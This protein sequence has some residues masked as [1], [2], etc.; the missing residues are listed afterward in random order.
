LKKSKTQGAASSTSAPAAS[1][2]SDAPAPNEPKAPK[3]GVCAI[4][5]KN[6]G[7]TCFLN[8]ALQLLAASPL[9]IQSVSAAAP[10]LLTTPETPEVSLVKILL[11]ILNGLHRSERARI[12]NPT[13][14]VKLLPPPF[15]DRA[16]EHDA[17]EVLYFLKSKL[18]DCKR[19]L[20]MP[21]LPFQGSVIN[22]LTCRCGHSKEPVAAIFNDI[23]ISLPL[24][25]SDGIG[26]TA[27]GPIQLQSLLDITHKDHE[28]AHCDA[29]SPT[30]NVPMT[31]Q[32]FVKTAPN[33]LLLQLKRFSYVE[34]IRQ[35]VKI[36]RQIECNERIH[37][38]LHETNEV[39]NYR[40][41]ASISHNGTSSNNGHYVA[42]KIDPSDKLYEMNDSQCQEIKEKQ[43]FVSQALFGG[44]TNDETPYILLYERIA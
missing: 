7:N 34:S 6:I 13:R 35:T 4:G 39:V 11:D 8:A 40:Y 15:H 26:V 20:N 22:K 2:S 30:Q 38:I 31:E 43:M 44:G 14:L 23:S 17:H 9:F 21:P 29:C 24:D 41:R 18:D 32:S 28:G 33:L 19:I 27:S 36:M 16:T 25:A 10:F 1:S 12:L 5:L 3:S 37:I 42:Y